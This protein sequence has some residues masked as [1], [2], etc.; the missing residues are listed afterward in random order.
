MNPLVSV[1][2]PAFN[3]AEFI[4]ETIE[5]VL[6]Q[7]YRSIEVIVVE[8]GS[9]DNTFQLIETSF[10]DDVRLLRQKNSGPS[11]ARNRG[12]RESSGKYIAFLDA[13]DIWLPEKIASQVD[14]ME[15]KLDIGMLCGDMVNFNEKGREDQSHF[16]KNGLDEEYFGDRLY[17]R[18]GFQKI[19]N[20][21]FI[22][23]PTVMLRRSIIDKTE[24]FPLEFR[25]S[26]DYLFW[27]DIARI[28]NVAYQPNIY[29]LRRKHAANLTNDTAVNV[30]IRPIVLDQI[31][32]RHGEYLK[33]LGIDIRER[34]SKAWFLIGYFRLYQLGQLDVTADFAKSF[35][36]RPNWRNFLYT[37]ASATKLTWVALKL[38]QYRGN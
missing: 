38:K 17:I 36:Y 9:Q 12:I 21:N 1:V 10:S 5:S 31:D 26:E 29:T 33:E 14:V 19:Y 34:Y 30:Q 22:S 27:L 8:D 2:I 20:K 3:A 16:R 11:A 4:V 15:E 18:N 35:S 24:L 37:C 7:T 28:Q 13:D 32:R 6:Q 23:T 25:F